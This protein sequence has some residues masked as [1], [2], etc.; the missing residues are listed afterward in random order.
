[1]RHRCAVTIDL[2]RR[3][4]AAPAL[5]AFLLLTVA[6]APYAPAQRGPAVPTPPASKP[7]APAPLPPFPL[8]RPLSTEAM[9]SR[10][11]GRACLGSFVE[12]LLEH[13]TTTGGGRIGFYASNGAG[14]GVGDLDADGDLDI[15][16]A[17]LAGPIYVAAGLD[18]HVRTALDRITRLWVRPT[19]A[20]EQEGAEGR[21]L[22]EW[23][24]ALEGFGSAAEFSS[25]SKIFGRSRTWI[26]ATPFLP[27][28]HLRRA[29]EGTQARRLLEGGE[30]ATGT[31][32]EATG[33][34]REVR[35][36]VQRRGIV[37]P[38]QAEHTQVD[39]LPHVEV[40]D[41]RRRPLHFH[42]FRSRGRERATDSHGAL[43]RLRFP[44]PIP[45]PLALGYG[46]HFGLGL[47]A[48]ADDA[49][50]AIKE[51]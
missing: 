15:V 50:R 11:D 30:V 29:V 7:P 14:V 35:R 33:Y 48:V 17:N 23:R 19:G 24:L 12:H 18:T 47:F 3:R 2:Q 20:A 46:C 31:L 5:A 44:E 42:R 28:G 51:M 21:G 39:L 25:A 6:A 27:T 32:A 43:L 49:G 1:M 4:G 26:S 9:P 36:L 10:V 40:H 41:T 16:L 34:P 8:P 13:T 22:R 45:G 38:S 37:G